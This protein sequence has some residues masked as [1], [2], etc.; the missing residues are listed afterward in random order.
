MNKNDLKKFSS[1]M[2]ALAEDFGGKISKDSLVLR[3]AALEEYTINQISQAGTWLLK[4]REQTFPA[5]PTTREIIIAIEKIDNPQAAISIEAKSEIQLQL[6]LSK[7]K[8]EGG[9]ATVD[10]NDPVTQELMTRRWPYNQW[11]STVLESEV[12]WFCKEFKELYKVYDKNKVVELGL[13][14]AP[15]EKTK[16]IPASKLKELL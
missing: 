2:W 6:V 9:G 16:Q 13:L 10:F 1:I 4:N 12:K 14:E 5:V 11:A 3:F 8:S 15:G 7:L